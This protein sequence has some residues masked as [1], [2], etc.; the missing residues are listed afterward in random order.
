MT[1]TAYAVI[2]W[3]RKGQPVETPAGINADDYFPD[4]RYIGPGSDGI[5]PIVRIAYEDGYS[6]TQYFV[7]E[8]GA[9]ALIGSDGVLRGLPE[10]GDVADA[11]AA[12]VIVLR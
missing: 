9:W 10:D 4:G 12:I 3:Q 2:G 1:Q 6:M 5:E 8:G 7:N 11:F